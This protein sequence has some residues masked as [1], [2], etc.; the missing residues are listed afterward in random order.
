[1]S[2]RRRTQKNH[3]RAARNWLGQAEHSLE[4]ENDVRG[5]LKLMLA[6]AE[7]SRVEDSPR[8]FWLKRWGIRLLPAVV[9]ILLAGA[10]TALWQKPPAEPVALQAEPSPMQ[11]IPAEKPQASAPAAWQAGETE[12]PVPE[13][14]SSYTEKDRQEQQEVPALPAAEQPKDTPAAAVP[15]PGRVPDAEKQK[16]MQSAGKALRQ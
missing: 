16:L 11:N 3:I 12:L 10:G 4:H 5:D 2:D 1:M 7:L 14:E 13:K 8:V 9:A 15:L 6:K